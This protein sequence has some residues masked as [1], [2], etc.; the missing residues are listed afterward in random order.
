MTAQ[1]KAAALWL[2]CIGKGLNDATG[3]GIFSGAPCV[4]RLGMGRTFCFFLGENTQIRQM[5]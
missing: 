5:P 4:P 1:G 2:V 3:Q